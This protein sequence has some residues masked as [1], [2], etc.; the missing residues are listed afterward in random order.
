[1][2]EPH[3]GHGVRKHGLPGS[4]ETTK[5]Q[6]GQMQKSGLPFLATFLP[7]LHSKPLHHGPLP[8]PEPAGMPTS[9]QLRHLRL[10]VTQGDEYQFGPVSEAELL[11][12]FIS[13]VADVSS[14]NQIACQVVLD[15]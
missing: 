14:G 15:Y 13:V 1:M 5:P 6:A 3:F 12:R 10:R 11:I 7:P 2:R 4:F 9:L 8:F